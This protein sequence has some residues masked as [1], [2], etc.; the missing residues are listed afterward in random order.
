MNGNRFFESGAAVRVS[1][2]LAG[3]GVALGAFGA[4]GLK[5]VWA[6]RPEGLETWKTAVLYHLL[7]SVAMLVLAGQGARANRG[8]WWLMLA[9]T[10]VFSGSLYLLATQGWKALGPA[11]PLGGVFL[12]AGWGCLVA[13]PWRISRE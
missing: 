3:L 5:A 9:G 4:H 11:T 1:A 6:V 12:L 13:M 10:A 7:H 2:A 8:A